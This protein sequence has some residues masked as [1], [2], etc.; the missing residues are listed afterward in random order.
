MQSV[1]R[2]GA[3]LRLTTPEREFVAAAAGRGANPTSFDE[4][5]RLAD[6][7]HEVLVAQA[8]A[9]EVHMQ[10]DGVDRGGRGGLSCESWR[11]SFK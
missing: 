9:A 3:E 8:D 11:R 6:S 1:L 7:S 4:Y 10:L 2:L 5:S